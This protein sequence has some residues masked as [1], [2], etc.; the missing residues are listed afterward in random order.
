MSD[1]YVNGLY[2]KSMAIQ[3]EGREHISMEILNSY[4][5]AFSTSEDT[6]YHNSI[7]AELLNFIRVDIHD[8]AGGRHVYNL[9]D[10]NIYVDL[11]TK[12]LRTRK[13]ENY[14]EV[15]LRQEQMKEKVERPIESRFDL[16]DL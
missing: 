7:S 8:D 15:Y 9:D 3:N 11:V 12:D 16:L 4:I 2:W 13:I 6:L 14:D 1:L 10:P 5:P